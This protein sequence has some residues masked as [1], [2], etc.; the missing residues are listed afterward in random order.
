V[1]KELKGSGYS[2][3]KFV[4]PQICSAFVVKEYIMTDGPTGHYP[5]FLPTSL[6]HRERSIANLTD[7]PTAQTFRIC[8]PPNI[9]PHV[10]RNRSKWLTTALGGSVPSARP[11]GGVGSDRRPPSIPSASLIYYASRNDNETFGRSHVACVW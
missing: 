2:Q 6:S 4:I 10:R 3:F 11:S 9:L 7:V 1:M 5:P 8:E